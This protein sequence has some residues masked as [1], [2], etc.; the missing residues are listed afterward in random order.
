MSYSITEAVTTTSLL[1]AAPA[2]TATDGTSYNC[3]ENDLE[4]ALLEIGID[5]NNLDEEEEDKPTPTVC[6]KAPVPTLS[7]SSEPEQATPDLVNSEFPTIPKQRLSSTSEEA[8]HLLIQACHELA[9]HGDYAAVRD[10][11]C[12][13]QIELNEYGLLAPSFRPKPKKSRPKGKD[14]TKSFT[15]ADLAI[16][17]D[18]IVIDCHWLYVRKVKVR[19]DPGDMLYQPLFRLTRPFDYELAWMFANEN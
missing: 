12:Q 15:A 19:V 6:V 17:R 2:F 5:I 7:N 9:R 11:I 13:L 1:A 10:R 4:A 16:H 3:L 18:L 8:S 14:S